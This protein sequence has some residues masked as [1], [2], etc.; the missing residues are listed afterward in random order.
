M[1]VLQIVADG[2]PGGG[3]TQV[4]S[5]AEDLAAAGMTVGLVSQANSY[6][7]E[8]AWL[9]GLMVEGIEFFRSRLDFTISVALA[10]IIGSFGPDI[11]HVHGGR[12]GF[13]LSLIPG[14]GARTPVA[15][16]VH[17]YHFLE[18]TSPVKHLAASAERRIS[19]MATVTVFV[20]NYDRRIAAEWNLLPRHGTS[21]LIYNG[22]QTGDLPRGGTTA[23]KSVGFLGRLTYQKNPLLFIEVMRILA[24]EG[25][26]A[27][28]VGGGKM[29][30]EVRHAVQ[31]YCLED[32]V[33]LTGPLTHRQALE[34]I[35]EVGAILFPSRWEGLPIACMEAMAMGIPVV[36]AR[37]S[38]FPE[39]VRSGVS[40][41][42]VDNPDPRAYADALRTVT[43]D[44]EYRQ[45]IIRNGLR[46]VQRRFAQKRVT[47]E[48][49][50][51]YRNILD[52][53]SHCTLPSN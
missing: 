7:L 52:E 36:A 1:R 21:T 14:L 28:V 26:R 16:T 43:A 18:K 32:K 44:S 42:L 24:P 12:A 45:R 34:Q 13:H 15:Y 50:R 37:V 30:R 19:C 27:K 2:D 41:I 5:L 39:I 31:K 40:G 22:I 46:T 47:Q 11:I 9:R 6:A 25:F 33:E 29:E 48:Y 8:Q 49:L 17:G 4:L 35:S 23:L 20:C 38:G 53:P 51:I 10:R 3:T